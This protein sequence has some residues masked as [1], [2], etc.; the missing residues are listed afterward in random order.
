MLL[1]DSR[2][3]LADLTHDPVR[4][5]TISEDQVKITREF[6]ISSCVQSEIW[7]RITAIYQILYELWATQPVVDICIS[8]DL[9]RL[10]GPP[11]DRKITTL[12]I[13]RLVV[14]D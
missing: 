14:Q 7:K 8:P 2:N 10:F 4:Q 13:D 12:R 11:T 5:V 6:V 9:T 1:G 3:D